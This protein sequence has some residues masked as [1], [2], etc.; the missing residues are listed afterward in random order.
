[1]VQYVQWAV[2]AILFGDWVRRALV[3][4]AKAFAYKFRKNSGDIA[5][6]VG[7]LSIIMSSGAGL[8]AFVEMLVRK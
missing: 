8:Y 7:L 1:M 6:G 3:P 5:L 4:G 2:L